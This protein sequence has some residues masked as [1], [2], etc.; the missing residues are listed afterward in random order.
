MKLMRQPFSR[1]PPELLEPFSEETINAFESEVAKS[2]PFTVPVQRVFNCGH[3][4]LVICHGPVRSIV[5]D[6]FRSVRAEHDERGGGSH[7][8]STS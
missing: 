7:I 6:L 2:N 1:L 3:S 8:L 5:P 4:V